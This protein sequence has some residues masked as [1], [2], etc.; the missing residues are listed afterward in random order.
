[1]EL[2]NRYPIPDIEGNNEDWDDSTIIRDEVL[3]LEDG[4]PV[5]VQFWSEYGYTFLTYFFS[6]EGIERL[7]GDML[8]R[9]LM[10]NGIVIRKTPFDA[11]D[12]SIVKDDCH[13]E[14]W[15]LTIPIDD[16]R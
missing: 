13:N 14:C 7:S 15:N 1:M 11:V 2:E 8:I 9:Y 6:S 12:A 10:N 16:F 4:R 5:R 3:Y